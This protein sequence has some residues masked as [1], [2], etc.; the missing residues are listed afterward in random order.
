MAFAVFS[1]AS[2]SS[3]TPRPSGSTFGECGFESGG[4]VGAGFGR[5][6]FFLRRGLPG[7]MGGDEAALN[8]LV[9]CVA[10]LS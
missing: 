5:G 9:R 1:L 10:Y 2:G 8:G 6:R 4:E 3:D 7:A